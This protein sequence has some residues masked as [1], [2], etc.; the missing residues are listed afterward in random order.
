ML[1]INFYDHQKA[2]RATHYEQTSASLFQS[3]SLQAVCRI[4]SLL[5]AVGKLHK[6]AKT[7]LPLMS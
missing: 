7:I 3:S 2:T 6:E 1:I 5:E 4:N